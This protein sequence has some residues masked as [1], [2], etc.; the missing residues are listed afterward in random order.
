MN[1]AP[2][3]S[4]KSST[5]LI[6]LSLVLATAGRG[7]LSPLQELV[8]VDL[9]VTD[10]QMAL[11]QG[12]AIAAPLT[13]LSFPIG[14]L[15]DRANRARLLCAF[16]LLCSGASLFTACAQ[17]FAQIF[18]A[19][20]L[21]GISFAGIF[22]SA[23]SLI[24]D[25]SDPGT[26]GRL[27][28][29]L[30]LGQ[31]FG[32]AASFAVV[33]AIVDRLPHLL[34]DWAGASSVAPWRLVQAV[35]AAAIFIGAMLLLLLREP[36]RREL[37]NAPQG[38]LRNALR[39]LWSFRRLL[40]PLLVGLATI[41]MADTAAEIWVVPVLTRSF[42]QSP[43]DFG[44]WM[45]LVALFAGIGGALVG[46]LISDFGQRLAGRGGV[47]V[48]ALLG[49]VLSIPGAFF[50]VMPG[51]HAFA[52]VLALFLASGMCTASAATAAATVLIPNEIRGLTSSIFGAVSVIVSSGIAP[53]MVSY[54]AGAMGLGTDIAIPLTGVAV[55]TSLIGSIAFGMAMRVARNAPAHACATL[56]T[57]A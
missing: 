36:A 18:A 5:A 6:V 19:R 45:G 1:T 48:G 4:I 52:V 32:R 35:F 41:N 16:A 30:F 38:N 31:V 25:L 22:L 51:V 11:L 43:A 28:M 40:A 46:G 56:K 37:G 3:S 50:P 7:V 53:L 57:A 27:V 13:L 24:S 8:S 12:L 10:N 42:H 47:L 15:V 2:I 49:A 26:R 29:L 34:P 9:R 21:V 14:R 17:S 54:S 20:M 44:S 33:G 23:L 39:E 55:T